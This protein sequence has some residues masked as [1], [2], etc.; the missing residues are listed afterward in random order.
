MPAE[1]ETVDTPETPEVPETPPTKTFSQEELN[2][3]V[4]KEKKALQ[5]QLEEMKSTFQNELANFKDKLPK[6]PEPTDRAGIL[7]VKLMSEEKARKMLEKELEE[8]RKEVANE[9]RLRNESQRDSQL[10]AA[11]NDAGV[12]S[13]YMNQARKLF[14]NDLEQEDDGSGNVRW[15]FKKSDG[16]L[17]DIRSG[18]ELALADMP[19]FREASGPGTG[20]GAQTSRP[21]NSKTQ[22][23]QTQQRL[24]EKRKELA[25]LA[26]QA[27][28]ARNKNEALASYNRL[29][30]EVL[31][32]EDV[33]NGKTPRSKL[34]LI[35][36]RPSER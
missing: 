28:S 10:Q 15:Y 16:N 30:R 9:R 4:L 6:E 13:K 25:Q 2:R 17:V 29:R 33:V 1:V 11:L 21:A 23:I 27:K 7:E 35:N 5:K 36:G 20:S 24:E 18:V 3:I 14:L 31:D 19:F 8:T 22:T 12:L 32:L 26:E 34:T